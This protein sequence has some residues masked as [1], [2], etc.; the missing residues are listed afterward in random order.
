MRASHGGCQHAN[1]QRTFNVQLCSQAMY[2]KGTYGTCKEGQMQLVGTLGSTTVVGND[3]RRLPSFD[4]RAPIPSSLTL[5][6]LNERAIYCLHVVDRTPHWH[7][8]LI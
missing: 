5:S 2:D 4:S 7:S 6:P 3:C 1:V 8:R